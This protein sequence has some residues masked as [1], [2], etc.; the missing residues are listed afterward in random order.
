MGTYSVKMSKTKLQKKTEHKFKHSNYLTVSYVNMVTYLQEACVL[1]SNK[2][3][4]LTTAG[5]GCYSYFTQYDSCSS[6]SKEDED[7]LLY[8]PRS[9]EPLPRGVV[10]MS[11]RCR[12]VFY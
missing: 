1:L 12:D 3:Q 5:D 11:H 2:I 8:M 9:L 4:G 6:T 10:C 7:R